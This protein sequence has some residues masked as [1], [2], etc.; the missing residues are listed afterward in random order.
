MTVVNQRG[1]LARVAAE[2]AKVGSNID[3]V[4]LENDDNFTN[5]RFI[6]Q[7]RSRKHLAQIMRELRHIREIVKLS[8][9]KTGIEHKYHRSSI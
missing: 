6:L 5:M 7:V 2:I 8:R 9:V 1:V 3:D 4:E